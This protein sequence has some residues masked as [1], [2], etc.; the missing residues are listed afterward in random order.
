[1]NPYN[2][3]DVELEEIKIR[4]PG[5]NNSY[6]SLNEN[7]N[8]AQSKYA[9]TV[10]SVVNRKKKRKDGFNEIN[11]TDFDSDEENDKQ[12]R[13]ERNKTR[14]DTSN[15]KSNMN[16]P[17]VGVTNSQVFDDFDWFADDYINN[18]GDK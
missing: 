9:P 11:N 15:S 13:I 6:S 5:D 14:M 12:A 4:D 10:T 7:V 1:M 3:N 8:R 2:K 17:K 16:Y 18:D